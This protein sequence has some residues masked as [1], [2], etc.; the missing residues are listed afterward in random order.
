M[1]DLIRVA[2]TEL[3]RFLASKLPGL[4]EQWWQKNV[5]DRLSFQPSVSHHLDHEVSLQGAGGRVAGEDTN[6]YPVGVQR[7]GRPDRIRRF[8]ARPDACVNEADRA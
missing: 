5:M 2:T 1:N 6:D 7:T 8:V 3:A 4:S